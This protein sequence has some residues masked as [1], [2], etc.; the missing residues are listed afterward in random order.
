[1]KEPVLILSD[2]HLGHTAS[3]IESVEQLRPL[4]DG[5]GTVVFNGDT[6]QELATDFRERADGLLNDLR[7]LCEEL[8]AET[9]FLP[10]NHDPG[11]EGQGWLELAGGKIVITHGDAVMWGGSPWSR[12]SIT[13]SERLK[14][15]WAENQEADHDVVERLGLAR[16]MAM[17]LKPPRIPKARSFFGRAM[18]AVNPPRRSLE[19]LRVWISQADR[20]AEFAERYFPKAEVLVLG[21][22]HWR[23]CWTRSGRLIVNTGAYVNPHS[24]SWVGYEDGWMKVGNVEEQDGVFSKEEASSVWNVD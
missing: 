13:R 20:A 3:K 4:I 2:L 9:V 19:I 16:K 21:H 23:G 24:A 11:W 22:F 6:F 14:K 18:D 15:L 10:G 5:A 17:V 8:G 12:E 7:N 1:M